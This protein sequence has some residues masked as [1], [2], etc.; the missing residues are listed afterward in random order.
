[1][2]LANPLWFSLPA[3]GAA[4]G[5]CGLAALLLSKNRTSAFSQSLARV[6]GATA[7]MQMGIGAPPKRV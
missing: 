2:N 4:I 6:L 1:M 7:V 3:L 5:A